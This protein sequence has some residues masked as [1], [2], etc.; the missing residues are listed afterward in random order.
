M[1]PGG[2]ADQGLEARVLG[3]GS[4][5][6][7]G[8]GA[9]A[10]AG[11]ARR[12]QAGLAG[13]EVHGDLGVGRLQVVRGSATLAEAPKIEGQGLGVEANLVDRVDGG[14]SLGGWGSSARAS[15]RGYEG[16]QAE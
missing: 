15:P 7:A 10:Q 13:Q 4:G 12:V 3:H 1:N 2:H 11:Q 16:K 14:R 6:V 5:Y 9:D 8:A